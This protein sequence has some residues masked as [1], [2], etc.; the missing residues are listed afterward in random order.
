MTGISPAPGETVRFNFSPLGI[1]RSAG[2]HQ[3]DIARL[4]NEIWDKVVTSRRTPVDNGFTL[5]REVAFLNRNDIRTIATLAYMDEVQAATDKFFE[6]QD[7]IEVAIDNV[8]PVQFLDPEAQ[9][10]DCPNTEYLRTR[11]EDPKMREL[12]TRILFADQN[13]SDDQLKEISCNAIQ[14]ARENNTLFKD[15]L[16]ATRESV[17]ESGPIVT[18]RQHNVQEQTYTRE[19]GATVTTRV[20]TTSG[21][22]HGLRT[23]HEEVERRLQE[24]LAG[25]SRRERSNA[26]ISGMRRLIEHQ[27]M[28]EQTTN[29]LKADTELEP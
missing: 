9:I 26:N 5:P 18:N 2:E 10:T 28:N 14:R 23:D 16:D 29:L 27:M 15:E 25:M 6:A 4:T 7:T 13:L 19:D 1:Q 8:E 21:R 11:Q 3:Q 22:V 17:I 24:R 12:D 20:E